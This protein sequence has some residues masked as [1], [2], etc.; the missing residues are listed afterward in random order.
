MRENALAG[1]TPAPPQ[2]ANNWPCVGAQAVSPAN[3]ALRASFPHPARGRE[4]GPVKSRTRVRG[5][6]IYELV[7][8][9]AREILYAFRVLRQSPAFTAVAVLSLGL[10]I[11][12]NSAIFELVDA[13]RLVPLRRLASL[14]KDAARKAD[15]ELIQLN[16]PRSIP[17]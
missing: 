4:R 9:V 16:R 11:G 15:D 8:V 12:A 7:S 3:W 14:S 5:R 1:E 17:N 6:V 2:F 10:G 13:V